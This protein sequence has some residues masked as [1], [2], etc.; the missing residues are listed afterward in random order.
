MLAM[1]VSGGTHIY[2]Y[3]YIY[4]Y[5]IDYEFWVGDTFK[6]KFSEF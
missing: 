6:V 3:I 2:I 4:M 5:E 1:G